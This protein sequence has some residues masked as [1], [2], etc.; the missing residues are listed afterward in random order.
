M[1]FEIL[2]TRASHKRYAGAI[3]HIIS[4][5]SK[6]RGT[7]IANRTPEYIARKITSGHAILALCETEVAGFCYIETWGHKQYVANSGLVVAEPF[8]H[9][10]LAAKI[11]QKAFALSRSLY[12]DARLFG[13]TTSLPVMKINSSLG[14]KPV[15]FSELTDDN[16]FWQ[17]CRGCNNYD[18]LMRN[19]HQ[20]CLCTGMLYDPHE[21]HEA[22]PKPTK[23][24]WQQFKGFLNQR[25]KRLKKFNLNKN[26]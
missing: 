8:R 24:H 17:G 3:S 26:V 25:S 10:G 22:L 7:G 18:I 12:P 21:N 16:D 23:K 15:T 2:V 6:K 11:K 1:E 9:N 13:I 19:D 5:A 14:Y 20:M 4:D